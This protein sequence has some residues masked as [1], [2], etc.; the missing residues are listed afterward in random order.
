MIGGTSP[1][2]GVSGHEYLNNPEYAEHRKDYYGKGKGRRRTRRRAEK[3]RIREGGKPRGRRVREKKDLSEFDFTPKR[4]KFGTEL[5]P[6]NNYDGGVG[7]PPV[8]MSKE[9]YDQINRRKRTGNM[10]DT[11][12]RIRMF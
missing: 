12:H 10:Q 2:P 8:P 9:D 1:I 5:I 7:R 6:P 11:I 3:D 4:P